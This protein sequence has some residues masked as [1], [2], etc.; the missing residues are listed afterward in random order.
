MSKPEKLCP[1]CI[2]NLTDGEYEFY[3]CPCGYQ[4]CGFCFNRLLEE[5][6]PKCPYCRRPYDANASKRVGEQYR[7]VSTNSDQSTPVYYLSSKIVQI[8]GI[9]SE[10]LSKET[11][12]KPE[13]LGQ[14]GKISKI[15]ISNHPS[16][17]L[18]I[19]S[20][21]P[22]VFV[23]FKS[24]QSADSCVMAL[25]DYVL[26]QD[27][28]QATISIVERCPHALRGNTC[29]NKKQCLKIHREIRSTD[30]IINSQEIDHQPSILRKKVNKPKP[31]NYSLFP[32]IAKIF[33]SI[34][35]PPKLVPP[36]PCHFSHIN[37][38]SLQRMSLLE[39][40]TDHGEFLLAQPPVTQ[41]HNSSSQNV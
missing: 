24:K 40:A 15:S 37:L 8:I 19:Q 12:V 9:P 5:K 7:P 30:I 10:L 34:F 21:S 28:L 33:P 36:V 3:P 11:L 4:V 41:S 38:Y 23:K 17:K 20:Q 1:L 26:G 16:N 27:R 35:P 13:Y 22:S 29:S 6:E 39:L 18:I 31:P 25:D 14:Y 32:N 2:S